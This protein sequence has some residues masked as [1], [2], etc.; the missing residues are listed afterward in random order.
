M[1]NGI[2]KIISLIMLAVFLLPSTGMMIYVH[3]CNM[4]SSTVFN[5]EVSNACCSEAADAS[6]QHLS[7]VASDSESYVSPLA[8]CEDSNMYIKLGQQILS[9]TVKIM[10]GNF[11]VFIF[12]TASQS[13]FTA[14]S[15]KSSDFTDFIS[16]PPGELPFI[17]NS[18]LRL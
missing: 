11:P 17:M 1:K 4:S 5:T 13:Q 12:T 2:R 16:Y 14:Q 18:S 6:A 3:Q 10:L 15:H 7:S 8:C 9:Q